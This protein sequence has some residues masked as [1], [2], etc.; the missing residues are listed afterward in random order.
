MKKNIHPPNQLTSFSFAAMVLL[1]L[2]SLPGVGE[3][4]WASKIQPTLLVENK[5]AESR[6]TSPQ[7]PGRA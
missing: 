6:P 1:V 5:P 4:V 7:A 2:A 3:G